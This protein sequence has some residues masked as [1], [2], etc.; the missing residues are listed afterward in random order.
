[1]SKQNT[2]NGQKRQAKE[3]RRRR[4]QQKQRVAPKIKA[5]RAEKPASP[6]AKAGGYLMQEFWKKMKFDNVLSA[7]SQEK[8]KGL[9]LTTLFLVLM[10]FGVVDAKSDSDL[11]S[12]VK[13]D[14]LLGAMYGVEVLDRQQLYR[15]RKRLTSDEY[16]KWQENLLRQLQKDPRTASRRDGTVSGDD[17]TW[18]KSGKEMPD[19]TL[20]YKSSEKR[21]GLGYVMPTTHYADRDKDYPLFGRIHKRSEE[22]KQEAEDKRNKR[23]QKLDGRRP[24]DEKA[25][26][27]YLVEKGRIPEVVVLRGARLSPGFVRHCEELNLPWLGVSPVT[28]KY[29]LAG[30]T[31][32]TAKELLKQTVRE[33]QWQILNDEGA[34]Y[35]SLGT[36]ETTTLGQVTLILVET[37][38]DGERFLYLAS[39]ELEPDEWLPL[40]QSALVDEQ[41]EPENSKLHDM[42]DLLA[43]SKPFIKAQTATFDGWFYVPWFLKKVLELGFV[44]IVLPAKTNREYTVRGVSKTWQ[45]WEEV[46]TDARRVSVLGR[47]MLVRQLK[48]HDPD[49]GHSQLIFIQDIDH[50]KHHGQ[51]VESLGRVYCLFCTDPKWAPDKVVQVYKLRWKIEEFYREVRQN[52]GLTRFHCRD[53]HAIHGHLVFAFISYI[54]VALTRLWHP[55]LKEMTLGAIKRQFFQA[56]VELEPTDDSLHVAFPPDWVDN[57]GLPDFAAPEPAVT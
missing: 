36:A 44:R 47:Q 23:R 4:R 2:P 22:Q 18:F 12:K 49:L 46:T 29:T 7:L 8:L 32:Q 53:E 45:E 24:E 40:L 56:I 14:P 11:S 5:V 43:K 50:K 10:L 51:L 42:L 6:Q 26:L 16:D 39:D 19:I 54:C 20:V 33:S 17:T 34:R 38:A 13:A 52:H 48:V 15:L 28:R 25:W 30:A 57:L 55:P 21:F 27:S 37:M 35:L 3:Q 31:S 1:M 9:P 41:P